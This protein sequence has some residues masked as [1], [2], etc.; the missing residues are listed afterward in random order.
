MNASRRYYEQEPVPVSEAVDVSY[1]ILF[2]MD[3]L[4]VDSHTIWQ[5]AEADLFEQMG[6]KYDPQV[7]QTYAGRNAPDVAATLYDLYRPGIALSQC[8]ANFRK[9]L[10][11]NFAVGEIVPMPGAL[12][13]VR[14][15]K[16]L[17]PMAIASGSPPEGI[18]RAITRLGLADCFDAL[19]SSES[20][21]R[22]KPAPDVF[23]Q[24][25]RKIAADPQ[26]C[27]VFED[28]LHGVR[29]G[30]AAEMKVFAVPSGETDGV[31][32]HATRVFN[33]LANVHRSDVAQALGL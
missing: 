16:G 26:R 14:R 7:A 11:Q 2:D 19:V 31:A 1:G 10:L 32:K 25:A 12:D 4:L 15:L 3:G 13:L 29:A 9:R 23:M 21:P 24:A 22:G 8:Q 18:E 17:A 30:L 33:S 28:S 6:R 5:A 27:L 20:V